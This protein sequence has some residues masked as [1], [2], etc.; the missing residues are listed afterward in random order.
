MV[1][2]DFTQFLG[3]LRSG[4]SKTA[5][6]LWSPAIVETQ[7]SNAN[8]RKL[9]PLVL[10]LDTGD[11]W[12]VV[13]RVVEDGIECV[14]HTSHSHT[15]AVPKGRII[16]RLSET[17]EP[18]RWLAVW[19]HAVSRYAKPE[20]GSLNGKRVQVKG[21][22]V[23]CKEV[24]RAYYLPPE[25][26]VYEH[27]PGEALDVSGVHTAPLQTREFE[28]ARI[29]LRMDMLEKLSRRLMK[30]KDHDSQ[31]LGDSLEKIVK[32]LPYATEGHR[33]TITFGVARALVQE[34]PALNPETTA[35]L[36]GPSV[37]RM[38]DDF[39]VATVEEKLDRLS[40]EFEQEEVETSETPY[41]GFFTDGR[42]AP[43]SEAELGQMAS[44][45]SMSRELLDRTWALRLRRGEC[46]LRNGEG[47]Y[48]S[49]DPAVFVPARDLVGVPGLTLY[50]STEKGPVML[51][52]NEFLQD[53]YRIDTVISDYGL[54]SARI[55][56][57][58]LALP[59]PR[60][61]LA[62]EYN[63]TVDE[64]ISLFD[65]RLRD[66]IVRAIKD[67][68]DCL[69][70][71]VMWGEG[72]AG[73]SLFAMALG[74]LWEIGTPCEW[75]I[76]Q[77]END[78]GQLAHTPVVLADEAFSANA[79]EIRRVV[80]R[81]ST[82]IKA[83][84]KSASCV[85]GNIR[86][87]VALNNLQKFQLGGN[88]NWDEVR[89]TAQRLL[90][91]KTTPEI[92]KVIDKYLKAWPRLLKDNTITRHFL[93]VAENHAP[94]TYATR[95]GFADDAEAV[96]TLASQTGLRSKVCQWCVEHLLNNGAVASSPHDRVETTSQGLIVSARV[97]ERFWGNH[98]RSKPPS[99]DQVS[100]ALEGISAPRGHRVLMPV[101]LLLAWSVAK[102]YPAAA[103]AE[104]F[105]DVKADNARRMN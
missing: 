9:G 5:S 16:L 41:S 26:C 10:D 1:W 77:S 66:W 85:R 82:P 61:H 102:S 55:E 48:R 62:P 72:G 57:G 47:N 70:A 15:D 69:P 75:V 89:A 53:C 71:L 91:V 44:R 81:T 93:W 59:V 54:D 79:S 92:G 63:A 56:G 50:R 11:L 76:A 96:R 27:F 32:G 67:E 87:I 13:S 17:V 25:G 60:A 34:W 103:L 36:F 105:A 8:V 38:G 97:I 65:T 19:M 31:V 95:S 88:L 73:K 68:N 101:D 21:C 52:A 94:V 33:D 40:A 80:F 22:D 42:V 84:Y 74:R 24:S 100:A 78:A 14:V 23:Q 90:F 20:F 46:Y 49:I 7:R 28:G 4:K 64:W 12:D 51:T 30:S 104:V 83:K 58:S 43:L 98:V 37:S 39:D 29:D 45:L 86:L 99:I 18:K 6:P 3:A 2:K 35:Q